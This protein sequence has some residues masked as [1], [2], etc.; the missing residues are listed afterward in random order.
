MSTVKQLASTERMS[1]RELYGR[2]FEFVPTAKVVLRTNCKPEVHDTTDGACRRL[3]IVEFGQSFKGREDP[4]LKAMLEAEQAGVLA[5]LVRGAMEW[6]RIGLG[7]PAE[8][9]KAGAVYRK[10]N[11]LVG[12]WVDE[13][14]VAV[15]GGVTPVRELFDSYEREMGRGV[16]HIRAFSRLLAG[17]GVAQVRTTTMRGFAL[18]LKLGA[19]GSAAPNTAAFNAAT[20]TTVINPFNGQPW[21]GFASQWPVLSAHPPG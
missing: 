20:P 21:G 5:W 13:C 12:A 1:A 8:V 9:E 18:T 7:M 3:H 16:L 14:T 6:Y 17:K 15:P 4:K 11:D 19:N 10:E 2:P